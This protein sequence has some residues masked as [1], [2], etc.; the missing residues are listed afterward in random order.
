MSL[1][2]SEALFRP[3]KLD[4][5]MTVRLPK[6]SLIVVYVSDIQK[7]LDFYTEL[8]LSFKHEKHGDG[9]DHYAAYVCGGTCL[10]LYPLAGRKRGPSIVRLGFYVDSLRK[11][12]DQLSRKGVNVISDVSDTNFGLQALVADPDGTVLS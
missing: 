2:I 10:E 7:S 12:V 1:R 4:Y 3:L 5:C 6:L 9:P 8:G 11:S